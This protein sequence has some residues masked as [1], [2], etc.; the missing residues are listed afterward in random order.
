MNNYQPNTLMHYISVQEEEKKIQYGTI[1]QGILSEHDF[2]LVCWTEK[3]L[4][5]QE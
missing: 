4:R 3:I 5:R 2:T 1:V